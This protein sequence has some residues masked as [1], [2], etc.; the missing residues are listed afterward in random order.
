VA[1]DPWSLGLTVTNGSG[2]HAVSMGEYVLAAAMFASERIEARLA[3]HR[4]HT[5]PSHEGRQLLNG[6]RLRGRT[7]AIVGY[8][9]VGREVARLLAACGMS[10]LALKA[11]PSQR[12][13]GGWREP[14][15]GD[16]DGSIPARIVGPDALGDIAAE[17]DLVVLTLPST[18][19]TRG[20]VDAAVLGAMRPDAWLVNVGRGALVDEGALIRELQAR[21]IGGAVLDVTA[22]E[23]LPAD[24]PLWDA[25]NCL[26]TPHVSGTG[27]RDMLWHV[28]AGFMA[29]NLLRYVR[30]EPVLNRT[31]GAAGY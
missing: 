13:D 23:P 4:T 27:D 11:D 29:E 25:P 16:P 19:R 10:I 28:T 17:A 12:V 30:G 3:G 5:W 14:G 18:P 21:S 1:L 2:L 20:I 7:A 26:V 31:S 22:H 8:G 15:T 24:D 9:S 6:R